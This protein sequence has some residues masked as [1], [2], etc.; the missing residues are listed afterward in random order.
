MEELLYAAFSCLFSYLCF[1][2]YTT[3]I[4]GSHNVTLDSNVAYDTKG[5]CFLLED[6][7]EMDN[8]LTGNLAAVTRKVETKIR[9][10]ESD[11]VPSSFWLTNPLNTF[12]GNV[13]AGS[14]HSGFWFEMKSSVREPT[15]SMLSLELSKM[16]PSRLQL[17]RFEDNVAHSCIEHGIKT[18][19]GVGLE[20]DGDPAVFL[21]SKSYRNRGDGVFIHNSRNIRIEGGIFADNRIAID[22]DRSPTCAISD[23][24]IIGYS[25]EYKALAGPAA[26]HK[27]C[28][29]QWPMRGIELHTFWQGGD[30]DT[31]T[32]V[33]DTSFAHFEDSGC[34]YI[35][36]FRPNHV[37]VSR[38]LTSHSPTSICSLIYIS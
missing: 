19:P 28:P 11:E 38:L 35:F 14:E 26:F 23:A 6:S 33:S 17:T 20:P 10:E 4:H 36:S 13:A 18:Y 21:N 1:F 5:H 16:N 7:G 37:A 8:V 2:L 12:V 31:G 3:V 22:I 27:L 29:S 34:E 32:T 9:P 30:L 25:P 24:T 15:K